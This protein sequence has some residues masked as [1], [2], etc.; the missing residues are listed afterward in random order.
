AR[1]WV[2]QGLDPT[3]DVRSLR[4]PEP[5]LLGNIED[6][7]V[8]ILELALE[9]HLVLAF[10]EVEEERAARALDALLRLG[11][12]VHLE[13]EMVGAD[14]AFCILEPRAALAL[15]RQER[16]IDHAVAEIDAG[17]DVEILAAD[18]LEPEHALV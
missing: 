8:G 9:V 10:A 13:A 3:Y 6:D 5:A 17:A 2:S 18:P 7:P 15:E 16:K 14:E 1:C 4:R 11:E 12:V